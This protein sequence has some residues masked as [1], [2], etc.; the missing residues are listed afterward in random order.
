MVEI[1]MRSAPFHNNRTKFDSFKLIF[2]NGVKYWMA[3]EREI[4]GV[5]TGSSECDERIC[6]PV[7]AWFQ[8]T[9]WRDAETVIARGSEGIECDN[10]TNGYKRI[11]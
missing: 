3:E 5:F 6:Q 9:G 7:G 10:L 8:K 1:P 2:F 11:T 4:H